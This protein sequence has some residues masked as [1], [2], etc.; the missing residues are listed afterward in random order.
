LG[1]CNDYLYAIRAVN[2]EGN[3]SGFV[4][5][6]ENV[7]RIR[8]STRTIYK[9]NENVSGAIP[10]TEGGAV[11]GEV[12]TPGEGEATEGQTGE[13]GQVK[14]EEN[15]PEITNPWTASES[16][17]WYWL[18]VII[19]AGTI[20]YAYKKMGGKNDGQPKGEA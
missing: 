1:N 2:A 9:S 19:A 15:N 16:K 3:G 18:V 20:Y 17:K 11:A 8:T 14:G 6:E 7:V 5:D 4:G 12:T 10:L 13:D